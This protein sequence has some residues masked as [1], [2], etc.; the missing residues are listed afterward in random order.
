MTMVGMQDACSAEV[1][2]QVPPNTPCQNEIADAFECVFDNLA[3]LCDAA[4][5]DTPGG[6]RAAMPCQDATHALSVCADANNLDTGNGNGNGNQR[7]CTLDGG[8]EC[9]TDCA[10]CTCEA[11]TDLNELAACGTGACATP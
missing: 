2:C 1:N 9:Q 5:Q 4:Q 7:N 10:T 3:L 8:C 11:G 6:P